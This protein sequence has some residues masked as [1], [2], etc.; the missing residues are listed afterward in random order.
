MQKCDVCF[1]H[2]HI[3]EGGTGR[4]GARINKDG[5]I[6]PAGYGQLTSLALDPIEKKPLNRFYPG[7]YILS[8]GSYGCNLRCPFCQNHEISMRSPSDGLRTRYMSPEELVETALELKVRGN[9]G[10]AFTYNEPMIN[11]EY[12]FDTA[13]LAKKED[14]KIVLVTNG[15]AEAEIL[16]PLLPLVNALNIDI[17]SFSGEYYRDFL[18]GDIEM[19]KNFITLAAEHC[20]VELTML[21]IPGKNDSDENMSSLCKWIGSLHNG[22]DIPLHISRFFPAYKMLDSLPTPVRTVY[23]F[24]EVAEEYLNFVYTG[25]C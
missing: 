1:A 22:E 19:V 23:H 3:P 2:C 12:I 21:V 18:K 15:T 20:H 11:H 16:K 8:V 7:S 9:I 6:I 4:C 13:T 24:K 5:K 14:L 25:N 10:I 17:K